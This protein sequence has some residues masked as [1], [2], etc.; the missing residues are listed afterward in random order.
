MENIK[1]IREIMRHGPNKS[2]KEVGNCLYYELPN[3]NRAK[4]F[5]E[6]VGIYGESHGVTVKIINNKEGT[7]DVCYFPFENYFRKVRCSP[8]APW[9]TPHI[10]KGRWRF[11]QMYDHV[12]PKS[13]DFERLAVAV[14]EYM[15]MFS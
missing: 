2:G 1:F 4:V 11:S 15:G 8:G 5:S 13:D 14:C 3:G 7:V 9:W 6:G 10:E 12:V